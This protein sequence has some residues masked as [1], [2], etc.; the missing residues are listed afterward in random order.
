MSDPLAEAL[1][2]SV[3]DEFYHFAYPDIPTEIDASTHY[4]TTGWKEDRDPNPWFSTSAYLAAVPESR[5]LAMGPLA[6]YLTI[7]SAEG[8]DAEPSA[9][10]D[11]YFSRPPSRMVLAPRPFSR[12]RALQTVEVKW[13]RESLTLAEIVRPEFDADYYLA[14]HADVV[15][16][17][18]DPLFHYLRAGWI[19]GR[20]PNAWFSGKA[21]IEANPGAVKSGENP[22]LHYLEKGRAEGRP[23]KAFFEF[24][25]GILAGQLTVEERIAAVPRTPL[26][27]A[28]DGEQLRDAFAG[29]DR[30]GN[31]KLHISVSHDDYTVNLGGLQSCLLREARGFEHAGF[32]HVHFYPVRPLLF[33]NHEDGDPIS[34][35]LIN[36]QL[37]GEFHASTIDEILRDVAGPGRQ[38]ETKTLAIHS[39]LGHNVQALMKIFE[40]IALRAGYFWIHDFASICAGHNLLRDDVEYCDAPELNSP[41]CSI[42]VYG[43][44]RSLQV[45]DH[46]YLF[47]RLQMTAVAP[48]AKT[49]ETWSRATRLPAVDRIVHP[50]AVLVPKRDAGNTI[51][52]PL[53]VALLGFPHAHKGWP[54]FRE[55]SLRHRKDPRYRFFHL[56]K[57]YQRGLPITYTEIGVDADAPNDMAAAIDELAIDVALIWSICPET[58]CFTAHEAIAG[59]AAVIT[60]TQSGNLT[61]LVQESGK[62]MTLIDE[63]ALFDLFESGD[64][65]LMARSART[66]ELYELLYGN[67]TADLITSPA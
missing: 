40:D 63:N 60:T 61:R 33:T 18:I 25:E 35:V 50:H 65:L 42:C 55:L 7:G 34:G 22:F 14:M 24:R 27:R 12:A 30:S 37:A 5:D 31:R 26:S 45:S 2:Q 11:A 8:I 20:D 53:R 4:I 64:A 19:E 51:E 23:L 44:R 67:L 54:V 57:G 49:M 39:L 47:E 48:A 15:A 13:D 36:G 46:R 66:V 9:H 21:Y 59:G 43:E 16:L 1:A 3:D 52:G 41:A 6:H 29:A 32:D 56:G 58:F 10:A 28:R 62:G 17:G 38:F